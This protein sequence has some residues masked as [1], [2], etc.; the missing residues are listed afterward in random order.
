MCC[1]ILLNPSFRT[2]VKKKASNGDL[3]REVTYDQGSLTL[4]YGGKGYTKTG[5]KRKVIS[6]Q[7][8]TDIEIWSKRLHKK[9]S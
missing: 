6:G 7:G 3:E 5:H 1:V 9:W 8:F 4:K 2:T